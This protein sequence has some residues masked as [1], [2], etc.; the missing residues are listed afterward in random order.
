VPTVA[1]ITAW[2]TGGDTRVVGT[3]TRSTIQTA[4]DALNQCQRGGYVRELCMAHDQLTVY[5]ADA[6]P[7]TAAGHS[8]GLSGGAIAGIVVAVVVVVVVVGLVWWNWGTVV[9][10]GRKPV[11]AV[12]KWWNKR[13]DSYIELGVA[14]NGEQFENQSPSST[15]PDVYSVQFGNKP[16][17]FTTQAPITSRTQ[18]TTTY[19]S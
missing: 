2:Y 18:V 7:T 10:Y 4:W 8:S 5:T 13:S 19:L 9:K 15:T 3:A 1:E 17:S 16:P 14:N 12:D 6:Q 11:L